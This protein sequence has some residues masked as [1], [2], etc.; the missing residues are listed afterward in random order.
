MVLLSS[1]LSSELSRGNLRHLLKHRHFAMRQLEQRHLEERLQ[2]VELAEIGSPRYRNG[3]EA[4]VTFKKPLI[5]NLGLK[6]VWPHFHVVCNEDEPH[7]ECIDLWK[8]SSIFSVK[9]KSIDDEHSKRI[10]TEQ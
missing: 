10:R 6:Y 9:R 3:D 8:E 2:Q 1:Q 4:K 7:A 5:I